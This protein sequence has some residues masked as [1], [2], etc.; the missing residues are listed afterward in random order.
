MKLFKNEETQPALIGKRASVLAGLRLEN[1]SSSN[2]MKMLSVKADRKKRTKGGM[3][4]YIAIDRAYRRKQKA[5]LQKLET[6]I[7]GSEPQGLECGQNTSSDSL[8]ME[9][10]KRIADGL[11]T[12]R[13][14]QGDLQ[15]L[16]AQLD[17]TILRLTANTAGVA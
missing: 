15:L 13:V 11:L 14:G 6:P 5:D 3:G 17:G 16:N 2:V 10:R 4:K 8:L 7:V 9:I 12:V 1:V